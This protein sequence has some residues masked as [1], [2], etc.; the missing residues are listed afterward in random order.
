MLIRLAALYCNMER[1]NVTGAWVEVQV[2]ENSI[3]LT[4]LSES[5]GSGATVEQVEHFTFDELE[6]MGGEVFSLNLSDETGELLSNMQ[7]DDDGF[8]LSESADLTSPYPEEDLNLWAPYY[9]LP[10]EGDVLNDPESNARFGDGRVKVTNVTDVTADEY[11]ININGEK[12]TVAQQNP[13]HPS[14]APVVEG[15]YVEGSAATYAFPVTRLE[16]AES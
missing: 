9:D 10:E 4:L 14:R 7:Q 15:E 8:P 11:E 16:E 5:A 1:E 13:G 3:G 6:D 12:T 2:D